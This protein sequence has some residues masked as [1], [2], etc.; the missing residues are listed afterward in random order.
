MTAMSSSVTGSMSCTNVAFL[1][2]GV[3]GDAMHAGPGY[4]D[5]RPYTV[6]F[7]PLTGRCVVRRAADDAAASTAAGTLELGWCEDTDAWA[8]TQPVSTLAMQGVWRG[9]PPL[10]LRAVGSGRPAR[11]ATNDAAAAAAGCRGDARLLRERRAARA[12]PGMRRRTGRTIVG[13]KRKE[14]RGETDILG[15]RRAIWSFLIVSLFVSTKNNK[16]MSLVS[17]C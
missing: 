6:L 15:A 11:L 2:D 3:A 5:A 17:S 16:I 8:Y 12:A 7:H 1:T 13:R 4:D 14:N 9:S 10:C